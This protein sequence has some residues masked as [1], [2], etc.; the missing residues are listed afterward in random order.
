[1]VGIKKSEKY[2]NYIF[3]SEDDWK[4]GSDVFIQ[5]TADTYGKCYICED[6]MSVLNVD[7]VK[8]R[9]KYP[10]PEHALCWNNLLP[11]CKDHCNTLKGNRFEHI[12][13]PA[14]TEPEDKIRLSLEF[15][16]VV[17]ETCDNEPS[18]LETAALLECV[19]NAKFLNVSWKTKCRKLRGKVETNVK[20]FL[21]YTESIGDDT[22]DELVRQEIQRAS[23]FAAFKR[24]I[25]RDNVTWSSQFEEALL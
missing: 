22:Y 3:G 4:A 5:L 14:I 2:S 7:H 15:D 18:T 21:T 9:S 19:Y 12:I 16:S 6:N 17:V 13:N 1:M 20:M 23:P 24:Q 25:I 10:A 8:P 11:A